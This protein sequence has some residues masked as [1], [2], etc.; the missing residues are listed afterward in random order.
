MLSRFTCP[1]YVPIPDKRDDV[2]GGG[3][4]RI[5]C[6]PSRTSHQR[7]LLLARDAVTG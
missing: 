3:G 4:A 1:P 5:R 6:K 2:S 7:S